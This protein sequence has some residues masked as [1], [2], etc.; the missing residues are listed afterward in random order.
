MAYWSVQ[1]VHF[2]DFAVEGVPVPR[3]ATD[4]AFSKIKIAETESKEG[5]EDTTDTSKYSPDA[6][7]L[8]ALVATKQSV[9]KVRGS[10][11]MERV[12]WSH[13]YYFCVFCPDACRFLFAQFALPIFACVSA[14]ARFYM[15]VCIPRFSPQ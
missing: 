12:G 8:G 2:F 6:N 15:R 9:A 13:S 3:V 11:M 4:R 1:V 5:F 14:Y 10:A 7:N